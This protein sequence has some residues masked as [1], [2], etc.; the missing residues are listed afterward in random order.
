MA[1]THPVTV[2]A[3]PRC[4][5]T[6]YCSDESLPN[7]SAEVYGLFGEE[8]LGLLEGLNAELS[9]VSASEDTHSRQDVS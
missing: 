5:L 7:R 8:L 2:G 3:L 1:L 6:T 4:W 9:A